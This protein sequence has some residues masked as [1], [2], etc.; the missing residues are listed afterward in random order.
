MKS[1]QAIQ[2]QVRMDAEIRKWLGEVAKQQDRS[3]NY[4]INQTLRQ[5]M[6]AAAQQGR[7]A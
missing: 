3:I 2:F 6:Q 5:A 7:S 4:V 1:E